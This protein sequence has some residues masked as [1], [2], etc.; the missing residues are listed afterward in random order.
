MVEGLSHVPPHE[1]RQEVQA[2]LASFT[3]L[4]MAQDHPTETEV[5][6]RL[7]VILDLKKRSSFLKMRLGDMGHEN[8]ELA[9]TFRR[10]LEQLPSLEDDTRKLLGILKPGDPRG[11]PDLDALQDRLGEREARQEI[12]ASTTPAPGQIFQETAS[13]SQPGMGL[14][15]M[16]MGL[17]MLAFVTFHAIA[18][19][20]GMTMAFGPVAFLLLG[21]YSIFYFAGFGILSS[22]FKA[23]AEEKITFTGRT[24]KVERTLGPISTSKEHFIAPGSKPRIG[25]PNIAISTKQQ[26][27]PQNAILL[28]DLD[29]KEVAIG[30]GMTHERR[31]QL[32][33]KISAYLM[34]QE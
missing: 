12:G 14:G 30:M 8:W 32:R 5:M 19:I 10:A 4:I 24:L 6:Q 34:R 3:P 23:A 2:W 27:I 17:A 18:M 25:R 26:Q 21:F 15:Q 9:D 20:G 7:G 13:P 22:A 31:E 16:G 28:T 29:G 1:L 11:L 33:D